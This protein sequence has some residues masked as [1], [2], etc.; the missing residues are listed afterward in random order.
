[1]QTRVLDHGY[2]EYVEH[3]GSDEAIIAAARMSTGK[4]FLGW[5]PLEDDC[6]RCKGDGDEGPFACPECRGTG[7]KPGDEKLLRYLW[8]HRHHTPFEM[9]GLTVEVQA[10]IFVLR[11]W[12]THRTQSRS[13]HS[14]R[15]SALEPLDY[16]PTLDRLER[17]AGANRQ[18]RGD[19]PLDRDA[20]ARWLKELDAI[21]GLLES[22]Y[23]RGL[24]AGVPREVARVVLPLARYSKMRCSANLRNWLHFLGLRLDGHA[25]GEIREYARAVGS[26]VAGHFPRTWALFTEGRA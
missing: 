26:L 1:M 11:Q 23:Q 6:P 15:Y 7:K 4:G 2:V 25:Q 3:W 21:Y 22:H 5:G 18:A 20:A 8:G 9:A 16:L 13:E 19:A 17:E 14:A 10:P 12:F 24:R